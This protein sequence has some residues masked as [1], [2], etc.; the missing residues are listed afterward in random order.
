VL[1]VCGQIDS[2]QHKLSAITR[3]DIERDACGSIVKMLIIRHQR[4]IDFS[5][6]IEVLFSNIALIQFLSNTL[7]ICCL[8]FLIVISIDLPNGSTILVK[9]VLFYVG[10]SIQ[11]FTFCF[12]GEY[13]SSKSKMI[14][15]AAYEA[16]WYDLKPNQN[17]DL[18][19]MIVRSQKHLTLTAGKFVVL[20][21]K[22]FGN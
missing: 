17:R 11:A 16:L 21:L 19:F 5:K 6:N 2:V 12:V 10:V 7:I 4:I 3:K 15:D 20:S 8:G 1:H 14:G 22:Q 9:S 13:L 18:F